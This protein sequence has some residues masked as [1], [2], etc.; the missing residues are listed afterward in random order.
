M[1]TWTVR[2]YWE[3]DF[4]AD[5]EGGALMQVDASFDLMSEARCELNGPEEEEDSD[6]S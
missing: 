3:R 6:G 2:I 1:R 5:D 4:Q